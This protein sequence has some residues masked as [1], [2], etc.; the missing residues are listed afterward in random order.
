MWPQAN[1][2]TLKYSYFSCGPRLSVSALRTEV[3]GG[4]RNLVLS[5]WRHHHQH[6][7]HRGGCGGDLA[8]ETVFSLHHCWRRSTHL[9]DPSEIGTSTACRKRFRCD[10]SLAWPTKR[11]LLTLS[12]HQPFPATT[13]NLRSIRR[14][15]RTLRTWCCMGTGN[16]NRRQGLLYELIKEYFIYWW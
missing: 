12:E 16:G 10:T 3:G 9:F 15:W 13:H 1:Q 6:Q 2:A 7:H 14:V 8:D 4:S 5:V 11:Y